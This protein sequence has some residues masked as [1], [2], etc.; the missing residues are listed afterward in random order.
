MQGEG[1]LLGS[2]HVTSLEEAGV[3]VQGAVPSKMKVGL[4]ALHLGACCFGPGG[5]WLM[6][7]STQKSP[8][9]AILHVSHS[10]P[11]GSCILLLLLGTVAGAAVESIQEELP[12]HPSH[13]DLAFIRHLEQ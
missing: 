6:Q 7:G 12:A 11:S 8:C 10:G 3:C 5:A 1:C 13:T 9:Q 4:S 2:T